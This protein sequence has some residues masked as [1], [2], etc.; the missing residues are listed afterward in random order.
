MEEFTAGKEGTAVHLSL[1][2]EYAC[3]DLGKT[4]LGE[5]TA[6]TPAPG[7]AL[8]S[9]PPGALGACANARRSLWLKSF[10]GCGLD[11]PRSGGQGPA[12]VPV[13]TAPRDQGSLLRIPHSE[14]SEGKDKGSCSATLQILPQATKFISKKK[15]LS[16]QR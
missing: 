8:C 14:L 11:L 4:G 10:S 2:A 7:P 12:L 6:G 3:F 13:R 1:W 16:A 9:T 5:N 15:F